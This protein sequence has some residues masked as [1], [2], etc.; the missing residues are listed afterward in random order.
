MRINDLE[1]RVQSLENKLVTNPVTLT[2]PDGTTRKISGGRHLL[3]I[4]HDPSLREE[5]E[6]VISSESSDGSEQLIGL[7]KALA[8]GSEEGK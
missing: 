6:W 1:K 5:L 2:M 8:N 7:I 4:M 3:D